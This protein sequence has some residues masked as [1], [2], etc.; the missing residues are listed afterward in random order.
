M[1]DSIAVRLDG[2]VEKVATIADLSLAFTGTVNA[3]EVAYV[4]PLS[5]RPRVSRSLSRKA[6]QDVDLVFG[7]VICVSVLNDNDGMR[8][9]SKLESARNAIRN[10]LFA[11]IPEGASQGLQLGPSDLI[12]I[13]KGTMWWMDRYITSCQ[14]TA[15]QS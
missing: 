15:I 5:E 8:S 12:K 11:W 14:R 10:Q 9:R 2:V 7:V 6:M 3:R 4:V 1:I 13:E